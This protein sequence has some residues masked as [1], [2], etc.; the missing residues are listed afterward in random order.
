MLESDL[1]AKS[2]FT[3]GAGYWYEIINRFKVSGLTQKQF[4]LQNGL[5]HGVFKSWY[6]RLRH[7]CQ[8]QEMAGFVPITLKDDD[9]LSTISAPPIPKESNLILELPNAAR[10]IVSPGFCTETLNRLLLVVGGHKC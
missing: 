8:K 1:S 6:Y 3:R 10:I 4:C 2:S 5:S 7:S 9:A